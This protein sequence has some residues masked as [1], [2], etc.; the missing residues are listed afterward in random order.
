MFC[1]F[2]L[3]VC[4]SPS[5]SAPTSEAS[6]LSLCYILSSNPVFSYFLENFNVNTQISKLKPLSIFLLIPPVRILLPTDDIKIFQKM[7]YRML[8]VP[9]IPIHVCHWR[10]SSSTYMFH[11]LASCIHSLSVAGIYSD[12][13]CWLH[14]FYT[15]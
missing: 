6:A 3:F 5:G 7:W 15:F 2:C 1:W 4:L 9:R 12:S 14:T 13:L 11:A 10:D 8:G